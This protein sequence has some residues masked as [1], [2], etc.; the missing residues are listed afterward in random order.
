M[1]EGKGFEPLVLLHTPVFKTGALGHY[2]N[3]LYFNV[4]LPARVELALRFTE[5]RF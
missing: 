4:V 5:T 1:A 2:A 3:L